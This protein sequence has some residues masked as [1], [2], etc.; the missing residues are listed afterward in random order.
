M[1]VAFEATSRDQFDR[2]FAAA[3]AAAGQERGLPGLR[4]H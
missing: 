2:F 4:A 1:R 3:L